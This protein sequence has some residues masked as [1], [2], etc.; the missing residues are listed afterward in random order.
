MGIST[1]MS[2]VVEHV[3]ALEEMGCCVVVFTPE[4]LRGARVSHVADR[5]VELGWEVID[6]LAEDEDEEDDDKIS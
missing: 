6:I 3:R 5:L 4:E 1:D 2:K